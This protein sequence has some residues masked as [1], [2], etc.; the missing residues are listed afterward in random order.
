MIKPVIAPTASKKKVRLDPE[1]L[2]VLTLHAGE[3]IEQS[4]V[5]ALAGSFS[6]QS[7]SIKKVR[8]A[9]SPTAIERE[10]R[11][12]RQIVD[13]LAVRT[14]LHTKELPLPVFAPIDMESMTLLDADTAYRL[15][16]NPGEPN[17]ALSA[18]LA[19]R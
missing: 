17:E 4:V 8:I 18:I 3:V 13:A 5:K 9:R 10:L 2:E 1:H 16:D 11:E 19:L 12:L 6:A 14:I 7:S 15:L